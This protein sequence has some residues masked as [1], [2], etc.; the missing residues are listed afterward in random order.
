MLEFLENS[1]IT[2][3][4]SE[5]L[6]DLEIIQVEDM[7]PSIDTS[8]NHEEDDL[9][10]DEPRS[11]I[12]PIRR[13]TRTRNTPSRMCLYID[14]EEHELGDLGEPANY[15][16]ALLDHESEKW[17]IT[18]RNFHQCKINLFYY[19][20]IWVL[21]IGLELSVIENKKISPPKDAETPVESPIPISSSSSVGSSSPFRSTTSPPDYPFDK[22]IFAELDNSLWIIPQPLGSEPVPEKPYESD[23]C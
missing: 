6:E 3:E 8:L 7:Y 17:L 4:A 15:K 20:H 14:A 11:D 13:S 12:I 19:D 18:T 23:A 16:A 1:L 5:S 2:Q 21:R 9:E 10:I 22:S